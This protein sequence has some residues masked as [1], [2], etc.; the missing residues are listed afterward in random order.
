MENP[1]VFLWQ[2]NHRVKIA[3]DDAHPSRAEGKKLLN[4][5]WRLFNALRVRQKRASRMS[6]M[7]KLGTAENIWRQSASNS[8]KGDSSSTLAA[9]PNTMFNLS[10]EEWLQG[11]GGVIR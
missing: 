6:L 5:T 10:S 8:A 2:P 4:S 9:N 3:E 7:L 11:S 1:I